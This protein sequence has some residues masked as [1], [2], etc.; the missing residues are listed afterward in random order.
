MGHN[1]GETEEQ[2][3]QD[4]S[5]D[6]LHEDKVGFYKQNLEVNCSMTLGLAN[7][8]TPTLPPQPTTPL[9]ITMQLPPLKSLSSLSEASVVSHYSLILYR[10]R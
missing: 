7:R 6:F 10:K 1:Q 5:I 3:E 2:K 9:N 8:P 4:N